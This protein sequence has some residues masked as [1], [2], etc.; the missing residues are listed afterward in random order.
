MKIEQGVL[1]PS[2]MQP[3]NEGVTGA[4]YA[5]VNVT[6]LSQRC[7]VKKV[8]EREIAAECFC[9]LLGRHLDLPVLTPVIVTD[10]RDQSYW[11]GSRDASYPSLKTRLGIGDQF[12][13]PQLIAVA[14]ILS[15]WSQV[16]Q[17]ISFD[18]LI[19]NG[20]RNVGNVLWNGVVFTIIDHERSMGIHPMTQNVLAKLVTGLMN[21]SYVATIQSS[22]T[23]Y[24]M[25]QQALLNVETTIWDSIKSEFQK[26]PATISQHFDVF[27]AL[28]GSRATALPINTANAMTP[29]LA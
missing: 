22:S 3:V 13:Q 24:A 9:G 18:E 8:G 29:L 25:A 27:Q 7:V 1:I 26:L 12:N 10:P 2:T 6:G 23:S 5:I 4:F 15:T 14:E 16:G 17:T 19:A 20:D 21:G 28:A 11:F